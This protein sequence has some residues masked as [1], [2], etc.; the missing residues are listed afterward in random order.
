MP[1]YLLVV[2]SDPELQRRI[3]DTLREASY[4]LASEMEA[5]WAK[6]SLLI[7][8]PDGVILN[9]S[10]TDGSGFAV[11]DAIRKDPDTAH[12]PIFFVASRHRGAHHRSEARRRYAPAEYF[13]TPLS[14]DSLLARVLETL[15]PR[16]PS[17]ASA[18]PDYPAGRL[19]DTAQ[20]RERREVEEH[21]RE[22]GGRQAR[23]KGAL[24]KEP[25][26]RILQRFLAERRT[27]ALLLEHDEVKKIVYFREGYPVSVRSNVLG[28]CLGQILLGR[29]LIGREALD[30]SVR[31]MKAEKRQQGQ[32]LVEMGAL[33]PHN[34]ERALL[35][36]VEAKVLEV[37][38]WREG[39]FS[40]TDGKHP[41]GDPVTLEHSPAALILEGIRRHY[42][43]ARLEKVLTPFE[44]QYL[45][46]SADPLRRLQDISADPA[47]RRFIESID[48]SKRLDAVLA[49]GLIPAGEARLLLVAMAEAG[50]IEPARTAA[51]RPAEEAAPA[52]QVTKVSEDTAPYPL[53]P[54]GSAPRPPEQR[55]REE[56]QG[57]YET[58]RVQSYF[59]VLG[60]PA[61]ASTSDVD[62]AYEAKARELHPDRF[63]ARGEEVR[64]V[65]LKIFDRLGDAHTT[66]RD[67]GRRRRYVSKLDR[68]RAESGPISVS[69]APSQAAEKVYYSGVEHLR[70]RRY[71]EAIDAF[72]QAIALAPGQASYHGALG[73]ALFRAAPADP[74]AVEAGLGELRRALAMNEGDP[75]V[76]ISLGRFYAETGWP[77]QAIAEFET[78]LRLNPALVDIQE[79]IRRL[80]GEA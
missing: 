47:E 57:I 40:F 64:Q 31:R 43:P 28:E 61:S 26:A 30:E 22:H 73:W 42:D 75:W 52:R 76:R 50:M 51:R 10:L 34:L 29:K 35:L 9:T 20:R 33:S 7:R 72:R 45:A 71:R 65:A 56:L 70:A 19:T 25:F 13:L 58:M 41:P 66:L 11:A 59:E 3:G 48:G 44:E 77:D 24:G 32:I 67:A 23:E 79:E 6:R 60:V 16:E 46:P 38:A 12:V 21:A 49:E 39:S 80:R 1:P 5:A 55:S 36:Q 8:P 14:V 2:E 63:R 62:R 54:S 27:G 15:P 78:A 17:T 74:A 37:F 68:E 4:E 18:I 53:E 69:P